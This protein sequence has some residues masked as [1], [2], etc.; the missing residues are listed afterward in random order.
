MPSY[1][2]VVGI[3]LAEA[4]D[5]RASD[6]IKKIKNKN[7]LINITRQ[8][9]GGLPNLGGLDKRGDSWYTCSIT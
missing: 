4:R 8:Y 7:F 5:E 9:N 3:N 1:S 2:F 6:K